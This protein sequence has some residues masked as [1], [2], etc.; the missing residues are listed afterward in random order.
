MLILQLMLRNIIRIAIPNSR[1][2][3]LVAPRDSRLNKGTC[4]ENDNVSSDVNPTTNV[5]E[6]D[7]YGQEDDNLFCLK[8]EI[9]NEDNSS[10]LDSVLGLD[11]VIQL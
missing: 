7:S 9:L 3:G 4:T 10:D 5:E 11:V 1:L 6:N 8:N 2:P